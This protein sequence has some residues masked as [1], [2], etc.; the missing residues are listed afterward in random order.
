[1][2]FSMIG[3]VIFVLGVIF[4]TGRGPTPAWTAS[5][6][7]GHAACVIVVGF[8]IRPD[9]CNLP[10]DRQPLAWAGSPADSTAAVADDASVSTPC[11]PVVVWSMVVRW[12]RSDAVERQQLKL[13]AL[14]LVAAVVALAATAGVGVDRCC[15]KTG[16]CAVRFSGRW[17][18]S[19]SASRSCATGY[20]TSTG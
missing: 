10:D 16:L 2:L 4:P 7:H 6:R 17:C 11:A 3:V 18:R 19:P 9:R 12:R 13:F 5:G 15:P 20:T 14:S 8:I 1:V